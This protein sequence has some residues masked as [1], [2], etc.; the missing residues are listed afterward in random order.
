MD[1]IT[2]LTDDHRRVE[3]LFARY[4]RT[5]DEKQRTQI[6]RD[7]KQELDVHAAI[8]EEIFY[9]GVR[10]S[11]PA[12]VAVAAEEH[13]VVKAAGDHFPELCQMRRDHASPESA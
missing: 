7:I 5:R 2:M 10:R 13:E 9:P 12:L 8:E 1:A 3:A 4:V 6:V 11:D